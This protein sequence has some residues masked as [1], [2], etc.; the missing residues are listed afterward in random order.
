MV[1]N[2]SGIVRRSNRERR[3]I[4]DDD[5]VI[6]GSGS[7]DDIAPA[8]MKKTKYEARDDDWS[9]SG[10]DSDAPVGNRRKSRNKKAG[11]KGGSKK[12]RRRRAGSESEDE[13]LVRKKKKKKAGLIFLATSQ[14]PCKTPVILKHCTKTF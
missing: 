13:L 1:Q 10:N 11:K 6:D 12:K 2:V 14:E 9:G 4:Y 5:F 3:V 8:G 7:E